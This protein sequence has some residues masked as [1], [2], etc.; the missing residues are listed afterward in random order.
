MFV[1][2]ITFV[3]LPEAKERFL[4]WIRTSALPHLM[5]PVYSASEPMLQEVV[6]VGGEKPSPEHGLSMALHLKFATQKEAHSWHDSLLPEVLAGFNRKFSPH[7]A[8]FITLLETVS[9]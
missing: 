2:N 1:Y 9:L 6:E 7:A 5:N 8:F 4:D 3:M